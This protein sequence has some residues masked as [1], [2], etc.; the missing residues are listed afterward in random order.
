VQSSPRSHSPLPSSRWPLVGGAGLALVVLGATIVWSALGLRRQIRTQIAS[1]D[2]ETLYAVA[3]M[4]YLDDK[5]SDETLGSLD[6]PGEQMQLVLK[7]SR[8]HNV[9][10]VRLFS[11]TGEFVNAVPAYITETSL[12]AT[13]LR[14]LRDLTPI[15][16]F[17]PKAQLAEHDLLAETNSASVPLLEVN[18]PLH[19]ENSSRLAGIAQFLMNGSSI[20][21]QFARLDRHLA[22]QSSFAFLAAGAVLL[23]GLSLAFFR[24]QRAN[25]LLAE[26]TSNLLQL[27]RELALAAKTSALGTVT[28]HLIH[29]LRNPLLGLH[30]FVQDRASSRSDGTDTDWRLA[31]A[32]T[33][34]MEE[35]INRVVRVLREESST[36]QYEISI[37]EFAKLFAAKLQPVAQTAGVRLETT[38]AA[39]G[40]FSNR[41][42]DLLFLI[43][44][45]LVQNACEATPSGKCVRLDVFFAGDRLI[46]EVQ[47][48]GCGLPDEMRGRL[49]T[50]GSSSKEAGIGIGLALSQQLAKHLGATL[51]LK[52]SSSQGCIF[53]VTMARSS[54]A[55]SPASRAVTS[56]E[57]PALAA[58]S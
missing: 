48:E 12:A 38:V 25:R 33:K 14:Q 56:P 45:N 50:P 3:M 7:I 1:R 16:H 53:Q 24:V 5:T 20:S 4:Q 13:D 57:A 2:G 21:E 36:I 30:S 28:S 41:Q 31:F 10:G 8:L 34:R 23:V 54:L 32:T 29:G 58:K 37:A 22:L 18:L 49:F 19:E 40:V 26:S 27:N 44:E 46:F 55:S 51:D 9:L 52:S 42:A 43:L 6:D 11:P 15:S 35:L 39:T 47:D 17:F